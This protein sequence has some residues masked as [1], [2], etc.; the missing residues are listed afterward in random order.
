MKILKKREKLFSVTTADC[1][2]IAKR[3]S[4]KGGQARNK[5]SNAIQC[6]HDP[7][8]AM[9]ECENGTSQEL[10]KREAFRLMIESKEFQSWLKFKIEAAKGNVEIE[11]ITD[12]G[13]KIKR[14][15]RQ[16]EV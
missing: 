1:R 6:F 5:T 3:G 12:Q 11:E 15:L 8:G 9:G 16:D 14:K 2:F 7:S 13:N 10:N 4:G